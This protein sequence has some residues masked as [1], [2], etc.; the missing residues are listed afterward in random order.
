MHL[1]EHAALHMIEEM[2]VIGPA[3]GGVGA[4]QIAQLLPGLDIDGVLVGSKLAVPILELAPESVQMDRVLHHRVV[5]EHEAHPVT[6]FE[7]DRPGL[8]EFLA[9]EA[10]DEALHVPGEM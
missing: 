4:D 1:P 8:G 6:E 3:P 9:V 7:L 10:P 5:D 2:A